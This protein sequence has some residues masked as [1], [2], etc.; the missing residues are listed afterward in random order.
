MTEKP[1]IVMSNVDSESDMLFHNDL[2]SVV[3]TTR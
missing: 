3:E 2:G 1:T